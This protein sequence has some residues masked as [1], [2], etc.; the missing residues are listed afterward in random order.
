MIAV[1]LHSVSD[2]TTVAITKGAGGGEGGGDG[3][4]EGG[5]ADAEQ[6]GCPPPLKHFIRL[7][8]IILRGCLNE[9]ASLK[10]FATVAALEITHLSSGWLND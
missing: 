9:V 5:P 6:T 7:A 10:A 3:E 2:W 8:G 1:G 4:G